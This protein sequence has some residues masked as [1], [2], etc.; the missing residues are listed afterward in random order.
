MAET[1]SFPSAVEDQLAPR[2]DLPPADTRIACEIFTI[3]IVWGFIENLIFLAM[4][5]LERQRWT[6]AENGSPDRQGVWHLFNKEQ[7]AGST[8]HNA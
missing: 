6:I 2:E 7:H 3:L 4:C 1:A 5:H 8:Y